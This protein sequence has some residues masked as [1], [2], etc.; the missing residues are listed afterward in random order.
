[1][2]EGPGAEVLRVHALGRARVEVGGSPLGTEDWT[3]AKPR[4]LL[5]YLLTGAGSTKAEIGL[6]LWPDA[7]AKELRN[8][9]H[10][11]VKFLRRALGGQRWVRFVDGAYH[12]DRAA[13]VWYDVDEFQAAAA[14][15]LAAGPTSDAIAMLDAAAGRYRGDFLV[16]LAV[17]SWADTRREQLR[18]QYEQVMLALGRLLGQHRRYGEAAETFAR[19][20]EHDPFLEVAHRGLMR[21]HAALGNQARVVRQYRDLVELLSADIGTTPAPETTAL[22]EKLLRGGG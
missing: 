7:S 1:V 5:Y 16:D 14:L 17:S 11:G 8:S 22:Y 2:S 3:Y 19:L 18:R 12:I 13:G 20:V 4:E 15:A 9:F 10:T 21:C 6:A